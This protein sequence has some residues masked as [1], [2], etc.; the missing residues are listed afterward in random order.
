MD[1]LV[2]INQAAPEI[3]LLDLEGVERGLDQARASLL[4][5]NFW[6]A[7]CPWSARADTILTELQKAWG[8]GVEIWSIASNANEGR[9]QIAAAAQERGV[10]HVFID[11]GHAA[12]DRYGA[13]TTPHF[14]VLDGKRIVRYMGALDDASFR[15]REPSKHY[16]INAVKA[17]LSGQMPEPQET[18]GYGC[19]IVRYEL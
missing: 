18:N 13:V 7:E 3:K 15:Q 5:L 9:E 11:P 17:L 6:S 14:F 10:L 16:L 1:P 2:K 8:E 19:S 4:V 12:A